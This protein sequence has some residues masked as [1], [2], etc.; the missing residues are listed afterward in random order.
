MA[1]PSVE[2]GNVYKL[3]KIIRWRCVYIEWGL[4]TI[5]YVLIHVRYTCW[6]VS[7]AVDK[8]EERAENTS[9]RDSWGDVD[10]GRHI[11]LQEDLLCAVS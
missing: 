4:Y 7:Q 6:S 11:A 2:Y 5:K 1:P 10:G 3:I 9:L 8:E